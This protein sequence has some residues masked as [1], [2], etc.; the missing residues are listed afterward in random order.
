MSE[1]QVWRALTADRGLWGW[2]DD[3]GIV[4]WTGEDGRDVVPLWASA[5]QATAGAGVDGDPGEGPLFLDLDTLLAEIPGWM[6][7]G[8]TTAVLS[9]GGDGLPVPLTELTERLLRL[10]VDG[11]A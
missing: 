9:A 1:D 10:Q 3:D 11:R 4:P 7:A 2:G 6:D 5:E 8:I